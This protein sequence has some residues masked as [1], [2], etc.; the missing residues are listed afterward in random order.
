MLLRNILDEFRKLASDISN[1]ISGG[2]FQGF[3]Q[4]KLPSRVDKCTELEQK[5]FNM[6]KPSLES[7]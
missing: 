5:A 3:A 6:I 7:K 1:A 2:G 4:S